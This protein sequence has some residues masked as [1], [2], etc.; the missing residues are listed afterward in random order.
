MSI[1]NKSRAEQGVF[2]PWISD[3]RPGIFAPSDDFASG[4]VTGLVH[5]VGMTGKSRFIVEQWLLM[6]DI[7]ETTYHGMT[8]TRFTGFLPLAEKD[9]THAG[10]LVWGFGRYPLGYPSRTMDVAEFYD[11]AVSTTAPRENPITYGLGL[12]IVRGG[13]PPDRLD[14][15]LGHDPIDLE[16]E[17]YVETFN[18][19][20][21]CRLTVFAE[22][23][24]SPYANATAW[25]VLSRFERSRRFV[26]AYDGK[27]CPN[28]FGTG[29]GMSTASV[30]DPSR[31]E[32]REW[33][34]IVK[35][36][37]GAQVS[38]ADGSI[39]VDDDFTGEPIDFQD[40]KKRVAPLVTTDH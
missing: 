12:S 9:T 11:W 17:G 7:D 28:Q 10:R 20:N 24:F 5:G 37:T 31:T 18:I 13:L 39:F 33:L 27:N 35:G 32:Y 14:K 23:R 15:G 8:L 22:S 3:A 19:S 4:A 16:T 36:W 40:L 2:S 29:T 6:K 26:Q 21:G 34:D 30:A 1:A 38:Y 25:P